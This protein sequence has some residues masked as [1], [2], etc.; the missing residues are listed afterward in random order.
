MLSKSQAR[1]FFLVGTALCGLAFVG[2]T[3]DTLQRVPAQTNQAEI[4]AETIRGKELWDSNNCMGCHTLFGEGGYYAPEL[5]K[6]YERR[7]EGFIRRMLE[8]PAAMYP[9]ERRMQKYQFSEPDKAALVAFFKWAN[10]VNLNGFPAKPSLMPVAVPAASGPAI[11]RSENRPQIF[12]QLCVACHVLDGQGGSV[13]PS[14]DGV[15]LRRD[16]DYLRRWLHDPGS[17]KPGARM[18]NLG[19]ADEQINELVAFL[20]TKK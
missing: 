20:G 7:G 11:A 18:P 2:L 1:A 16:D 19:L 10:R 12:N 3:V 13:G 14:L 4:T 5:T 17:V 8:D 9:G 15:A 6:V